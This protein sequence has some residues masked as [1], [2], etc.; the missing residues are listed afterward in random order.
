MMPLARALMQYATIC[1]QKRQQLQKGDKKEGSGSGA[2][3]VVPQLPYAES[4]RSC[5]VFCSA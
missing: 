2:C 1:T 5:M 4:S 3:T